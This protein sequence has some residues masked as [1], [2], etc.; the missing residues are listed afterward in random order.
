MKRLNIL[1]LLGGDL[2]LKKSLVVILALLIAATA[3]AEGVDK[4]QPSRV[5][6]N[7]LRQK[8]LKFSE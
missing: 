6:R 4:N 5:K 2:V 8:H 3:L 7:N 1:I